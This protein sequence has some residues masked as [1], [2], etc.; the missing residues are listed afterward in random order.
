V[1]S[2]NKQVIAIIAVVWAGVIVFASLY[3]ILE[4]NPNAVDKDVLFQLAAFNTFSNGSFGGFMSYG[5]IEKHGD[6]GI[7]TFD[8]LNGEMIAL[9]G[10]Y[11]QIPLDGK[12]RVVTGN[13][14]APYATVTFFDVDQSFTISGVNYTQLKAEIDKVL[15]SKNVIY[16]IKV[17]GIF[18]FAQTRAPAQQTQPYPALSVALKNQAVFNLT[19]DSATA[20]GFWFPASMDGVDYVGYHLHLITDDHNAGGHLLDCIIRNATV[21]IDQTNKFSLV[22]P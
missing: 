4:F 21:E 16:A 17:S 13:M 1:G 5:E 7:G 18:D 3:A 12:P 8:G 15:P 9:N 19:D 22:L 2:L 10:V 20:V 14:E 6:F 11:Y